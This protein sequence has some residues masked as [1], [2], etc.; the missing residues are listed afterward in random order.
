MLA[1]QC[2][3]WHCLPTAGGW[4]DQDVLDIQV[5]GAY[6]AAKSEAAEQERSRQKARNK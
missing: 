6:S 2:D 5:L 1:Q 4:Y 3:E